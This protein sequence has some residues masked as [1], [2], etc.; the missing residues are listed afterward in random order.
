MLK[1]VIVM[2]IVLCALT[3]YNHLNAQK[4]ETTVTAEMQK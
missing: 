2:T 4:S 3:A 1:K